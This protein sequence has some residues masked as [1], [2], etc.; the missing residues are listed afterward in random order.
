VLG[1]DTNVIVRFL[2][3]DDDRQT[4]MAGR[5]MARAENQPVRIALI[6][7]VEAFWVLTKTKKFPRAR[8]FAAFRDLLQSSQ[9]V[10][11]EAE[12]VALALEQAEATGS[13]LADALIALLN[14][15][16]GCEATATFD[17]DAQRLE[18]MIAVEARL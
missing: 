4:P 10:I 11:E 3:I 12:L 1:V 8:V 7:I 6:V 13:D 16:A 17:A 2:A 15:H 5:F 14:H 9:F 18:H